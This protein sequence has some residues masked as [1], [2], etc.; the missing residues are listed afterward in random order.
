M[1]CLD[2]PS[3]YNIFSTKNYLVVFEYLIVIE[4]LGFLYGSAGRFLSPENLVG[5]SGTSF[6]PSAASLSGLFAAYHAKKVSDKKELEEKLK[7]LQLAGPFWAKSNQ[8]QNFYVP[9]PFN[10]LI[11]KGERSLKYQLS[12][13]GNKWLDQCGNSPTDKFESGTW[14]AIQDWQ[15]LNSPDW[16]NPPQVEKPPWK[17]TP[18]LHPQLRENERRVKIEQLD[19][20]SERGSLF[21]ENAMQL[22]SDACLVYLSNMEI[23]C[24]WYRFGGEGHLVNVQC[25]EIKNSTIQSL[26]AE[27]LKQ[28]FAL[29]TPAV[30]GS[31]R[32]SYREPM[33]KKGNTWEPVWFESEDT[34][35]RE[36]K[37]KPIL[38]ERPTPFRYRLGN[39]RNQDNQDIHQPDRPKLLSRGRYAVP[40][41]SVY[42]LD[43]PLSELLDKP[44]DPKDWPT[45]Q[46]WPDEWFPQEGY[47]F[48]RW[49]CGLALPLPSAIATNH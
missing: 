31:N 29:I 1:F 45:W 41:G 37:V 48:K 2:L 6:P 46:D 14:I 32:L 39:Q 16:N 5:R 9:T 17:P 30:W 10:C 36:N 12:W 25:Q 7:P 43:K 47:S 19:D 26:L 34:D 28:S 13:H 33:V 23:D 21:L 44:P 15:Q 20:G 27:P 18:Q 40:A 24:G 38:T 11:L 8:P 49:G 3:I 35:D 42:V 4:P 22:D